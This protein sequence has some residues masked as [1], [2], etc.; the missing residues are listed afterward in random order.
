VLLQTI[1]ATA[2][3]SLRQAA[4]ASLLPFDD[5][6]IGTSVIKLYARLSPDSRGVAQGLLASRKIWTRQLLEAVDAGRIEKGMVPVETVRKMTAHKDERITALVQKHWGKVQGATTAEMQ[7]QI[8]RWQTAIRAGTGSPYAGKKLFNTTCAKC[9]ALFGKGGN[10]GPD[11]TTYKRDDLANMLL[12]IV[13]PSAEIREGF[14]THLVVTQDGRVLTG[15]LVDR[16][17]R[18]VVLRSAEGTD[19]S[20]PRSN[21]DEMRVIPQSIMPEGLLGGMNEQQVRDLFAYLR[22]TQPLND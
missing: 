7:K 5:P 6:T 14:E 20:L 18:L 8:E 16:D 10:I 9:H 12:N 1:G 19:I 3:A 11:L 4:L 22:S 2:D 17:N 21:I 13:N 15:F